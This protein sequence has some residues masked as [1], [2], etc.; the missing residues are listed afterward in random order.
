LVVVPE[1]ADFEVRREL[2]RIGRK[3]SVQRL[4]QLKLNLVYAPI[5]TTI[6]LLAAEYWAEARLKGQ[7]T[8]PD[9]GL[10]ADVIVAAQTT[11]LEED[12]G[13]PAVVAT[14]NTAHLSRFVD[15][16]HWSAIT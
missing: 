11:A 12:F 2:L 3:R 4:D 1:I 15:A 14:T 8:A 9:L 6:M 5:T 16:R 13:L 10:D 7:P